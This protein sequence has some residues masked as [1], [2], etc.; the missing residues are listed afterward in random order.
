MSSPLHF[1]LRV[2]KWDFK[3]FAIQLASK[4][5]LGL[6]VLKLDWRYEDA[7]DPIRLIFLVVERCVYNSIDYE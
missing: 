3:D 4:V 1:N 7:A 6:K 2:R 5:D